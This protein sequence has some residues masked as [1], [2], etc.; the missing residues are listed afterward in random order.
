MQKIEMKGKFSKKTDILQT[1][2]IT[3]TCIMHPEIHATKPGKCPKC[4]MDLIKEKAK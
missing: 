1:Q 4:G 2:S 3:H